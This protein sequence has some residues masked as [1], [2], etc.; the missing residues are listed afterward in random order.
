MKK[1]APAF[2]RPVSRKFYVSITARVSE[3]LGLI[4]RTDAV[5]TT[6]DCIDRYLTDGTGPT[7]TADPAVILTFALLRSEIDKA[8]GRSARARRR[9][10]GKTAPETPAGSP[11]SA[12]QANTAVQD[13]ALPAETDTSETEPDGDPEEPFVPR[14]RRERRLCEQEARRAARR[15]V[16]RLTRA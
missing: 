6:M 5:S 14:N 1:H 7:D 13:C 3:S 16:R 12:S 9:R 11:E 10:T 15:L 2:T 8:V 4:G